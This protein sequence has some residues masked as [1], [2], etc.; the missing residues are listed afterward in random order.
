MK[1][2]FYQHYLAEEIKKRNKAIALLSARKFK[3]LMDFASHYV[4]SE[5]KSEEIVSDIIWMKLWL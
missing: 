5:H 3:E 1:D 2:L 4:K